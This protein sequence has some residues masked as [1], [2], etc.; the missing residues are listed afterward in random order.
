MADLEILRRPPE[1]KRAK[2]PLFT[3]AAGAPMPKHF[4]AWMERVS[5]ARGWAPGDSTKFSVHSFRA[6]LA[7]ALAAAG[8]SDARI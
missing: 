1:G 6:H 7:C 8:A 4:D 3:T 5:E 2:T